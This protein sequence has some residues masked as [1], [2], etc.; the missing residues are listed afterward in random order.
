MLS[1]LFPLIRVLRYEMSGPVERAATLFFY[2]NIPG[3]FVV[4]HLKYYQ[5]AQSLRLLS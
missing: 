4:N 5:G 2:C 3:C 1:I